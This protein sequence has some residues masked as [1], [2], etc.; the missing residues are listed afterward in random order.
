[1]LHL[2]LENCVSSNIDVYIKISNLF[3]NELPQINY[4]IRKSK[5]YTDNDILTKCGV[6][7]F[8]SLIPVQS[9]IH[10]KMLY[11]M[12]NDQCFQF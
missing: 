3:W 1:V 8:G 7:V 10:I 5:S 11:L 12:N 6:E 4:S 2:P 9:S